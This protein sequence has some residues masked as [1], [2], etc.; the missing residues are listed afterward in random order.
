[1]LAGLFHSA[2]F[3]RAGHA[4]SGRIL[5]ALALLAVFTVP[6]LALI[7]PLDGVYPNGLMRGRQPR[8]GLRI[9]RSQARRC[10]P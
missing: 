7:W 6:A 5:G 4:V 10:S 2:E 3:A 8:V 1:L 9:W